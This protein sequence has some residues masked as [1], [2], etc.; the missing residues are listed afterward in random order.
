MTVSNSDEST[1]QLFHL[2]ALLR[3]KKWQ[4]ASS[5]ANAPAE[6]PRTLCDLFDAQLIDRNARHTICLT[7]KGEAVVQEALSAFVAF[8]R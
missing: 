3:L 5:P 8:A 6:H 1:L 2:E 4:T 7:P